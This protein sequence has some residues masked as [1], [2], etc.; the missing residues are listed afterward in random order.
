MP[1]GETLE[2]S[3]EITHKGCRQYTVGQT[4]PSMGSSN[5]EGPITNG[6]QPCTT[7]SQQ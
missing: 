5:R 3:S 2:A 7:D 4:V 1:E 6:V